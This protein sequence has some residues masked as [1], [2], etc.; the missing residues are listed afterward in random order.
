[1]KTSN[2]Q[3]GGVKGKITSSATKPDDCTFLMCTFPSTGNKKAG[4]LCLALRYV[5]MKWVFPIAQYYTQ[6]SNITHK[7]VAQETHC[8]L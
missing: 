7:I 1:M 4:P 2:A 8:L 5:H 6:D 3:E